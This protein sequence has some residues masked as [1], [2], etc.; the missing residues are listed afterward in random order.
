MGPA[1][2]SAEKGKGEGEIVLNQPEG[3]D[4]G[5]AVGVVDV[6]YLSFSEVLTL[7]PVTSFWTKCR[8]EERMAGWVEKQLNVWVQRVVAGGTKPTR[9]QMVQPG[10][11]SGARAALHLC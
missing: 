10:I 7:S 11:D 1:V 2:V 5:D 8:L 9:G 6:L 3:G 4:R